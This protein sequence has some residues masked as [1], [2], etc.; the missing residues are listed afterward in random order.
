[1]ALN[2]YF[3]NAMLVGGQYDRRY[4]ADDYSDN[5]AAVISNGVRRSGDNDFNVTSSGLTLTVKRG[6]AMVGGKAIRLDADYTLPDIA[7]PVGNFSRIDAVILRQDVSE[8]VRAPSLL[9][10]AGTPGS[11]PVAPA[12]TRT[13]TVYDLVLAHVLVAPSATSLVVTDTRPNADI[14]GWITSPVGYDDYFTSLDSAFQTWFQRERDTLSSVTL[15]KRYSDLQ[16]VQNATQTLTFNIP[17][18]DAETCFVEVY[19]NGIF[20]NRHSISGNVITFQGTL[21]AGTNVLVNCYK[22]IDGTGIM[23]VAD[24]ITDLQN[25]VDAIEADAHF[26]YKCTG[27]N[28]NISLSQIAQA[29][30]SGSYVASNVTPAA[31]AF[32]SRIGGNTYLQSLTADAQITVDVVGKPGVTTPFA[33]AGTEA[34][35]Y[36]WFSFGTA[37]SNDKRVIF[38]FAKCDVVKITCAASKNNII[39]YGNDLNVKNANVV[40]T[41]NGA[42][43]VI[44]MV[45]GSDNTG[46][47]IFEDCRLTVDTTGRA[48]IAENGTFINCKCKVMS[49]ANHAFC[50]SPRNTG[51]V[52]LIGG[53]FYAYAKASGYNAAIFYTYSNDADVVCMATNINCPTVGVT[54]YFQQYVAV[55]NGGKV[56]INGLVSTQD[57]TGTYK[58]ITGQIWKSKAR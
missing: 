39:F 25:R 44:D 48:R 8:A 23:D 36:R 50:F 54:G 33:G 2:G 17:Q 40:A 11:T 42:S 10:V 12:P 38:D 19:V 26:S 1:M 20:D 34:S 31:A 37:G 45:A 29:F 16:V 32:L 13:S 58:E 35:R 15:F 43:C 49:S 28:D 30:I 53:V 4:N 57:S 5:L 14:C 41:N 56:V 9:I 47:I 6:Y 27:L 55:A 3:Y 21:T 22:S 24:E 7:P 18:Y 52:Q 51:L 46:S